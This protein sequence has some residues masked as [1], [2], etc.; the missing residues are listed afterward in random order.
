MWSNEAH[1]RR[2][3]KWYFTR[4]EIVPEPSAEYRTIM[5]CSRVSVFEIW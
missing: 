3:L 2:R 4:Q 5:I 1:R